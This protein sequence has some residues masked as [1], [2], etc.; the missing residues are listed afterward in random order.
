MPLPESDAATAGAS[1]PA[2]PQPT[3]AAST[4]P[5][6]KLPQNLPERRKAAVAAARRVLQ[7][8]LSGKARTATRDSA[9]TKPGS[10]ATVRP[11]PPAAK[12]SAAPDEE[13]TI[14]FDE[15]ARLDSPAELDV[16]VPSHAPERA[17]TTRTLALKRGKPWKRDSILR[18]TGVGLAAVFTIA[19][20]VSIVGRHAPEPAPVPAP[21]VAGLPDPGTVIRDCP[22]CPS[23]IVLPA[24]RFQQG[25][26][27]TDSG[28]AFEKPLHWVMINRPL[29]M[30]TNAVT[31]DEFQQFIAATGRNMQG[32]DTYDGA[33]K[34]RPKNSWKSPGFPQSGKHPVTCTSWNDAVAYAAWLSL[35]TGHLYRLPS[36]SE[37]EY[38]ARAGGAAS[39]P[40]NPDGSGA[41]ENGNVA[42][43][44]AVHRYPGWSVFG[45]KDGYVY[46]APVGSFKSNAFGLNDMLGNVFQWTRDC[47]S[48]DYVGA[49]IDGSARTDGNCADHELRG[50]SWFSTPA[51][52]RANY[53]N[54]FAADYRTSSVGIRLVRDFE[55]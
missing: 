45:C 42:D 35:K 15:V 47:W 30:S 12:A 33:W 23:M 6:A 40:W 20:V 11:S 8:W 5:A 13:V 51:Y 37:W 31:V 1:A 53:R 3:P 43:E 14:D 24:G 48:A 4:P 46:T 2:A 34:L 38:A 26:A 7:D 27:V 17:S 39:L 21:A 22:S 25:S 50:G 10:A 32:C 41:C 19:A 36:A 49:P 44:S 52:V 9:T 55:R 29:A 54:H 18:A 28:S 16:A